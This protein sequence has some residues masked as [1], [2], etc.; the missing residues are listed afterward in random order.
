MTSTVRELRAKENTESH[1]I[2]ISKKDIEQ[3]RMKSTRLLK[4]LGL[5]GKVST[6]Q[7]FSFNYRYIIYFTYFKYIY[8][9]IHIYTHTY[10]YNILFSK[11]LFYAFFV[12]YSPHPIVCFQVYCFV[13]IFLSFIELWLI[14]NVMIISAI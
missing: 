4:Q 5:S 13:F 3:S 10:I 8:V 14:Y 7:P 6:G 2:Y 1:S 11:C 9:Q 12:L